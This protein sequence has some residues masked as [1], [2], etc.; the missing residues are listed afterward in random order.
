[1]AH[2]DFTREQQIEGSSDRSFAAVF[3]LVFGLV[4]LWPVLFGGSPRGW[5]AAVALA[6][7]LVGMLRPAWLAPLNRLWM[8][9]GLLLGAVVSPIALGLLF[10]GVLTPIGVL[11]RLFGSDPLRLR[12]DPAMRSYWLPRQPPGPPPRSMDR[13]F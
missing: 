5:A 9:F 1:M 12:R 13:Q 4:C 8:R 3:A 11:M 10:Y 2:E 6:F 7:A